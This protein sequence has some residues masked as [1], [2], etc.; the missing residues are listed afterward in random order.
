MQLQSLLKKTADADYLKEMI[1]FA[2]N[3]R[4]R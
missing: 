2:T 3:R 1:G 4:A